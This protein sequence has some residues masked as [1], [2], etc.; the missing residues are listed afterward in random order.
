MRVFTI[1]PNRRPLWPRTARLRVLIRH[2]L[3]RKGVPM[4]ALL[5][6]PTNDLLRIALAL[7]SAS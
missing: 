7:R 5:G 4:S 2:R 1:P 6:K 3:N